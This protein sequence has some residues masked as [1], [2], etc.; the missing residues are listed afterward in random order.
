MLF[1]QPTTRSAP[2]WSYY[3]FPLGPSAG[4]S[5]E[6]ASAG[7]YSGL[8][9]LGV[10]QERG[11]SS[12][13]TRMGRLRL[14]HVFQRCRACT[15]YLKG[16]RATVTMLFPSIAGH[17]SSQGIVL[18]E[19]AIGA[20]SISTRSHIALAV[21]LA[22]ILHHHFP[23]QGMQMSGSQ[24]PTV[25]VASRW[26]EPQP[27]PA[28]TRIWTYTCDAPVEVPFVPAPEPALMYHQVGSNGRGIPAAG[29][30]VWTQPRIVQ[31]CAHI[32]HFPPRAHPPFVF[33]LLHFQA[34]G[35]VVAASDTAFDWA[36]IGALAAEAFN[37]PWFSQGAY[38]IVLHGRVL[39][40]GEAIG[41]PPHGTI[42]HLTRTSLQPR[43]GQ[44]IWDTPADPGC[45][46]PFDYDI[47]RGHR[48]H[49]PVYPLM[50]TGPATSTG[51]TQPARR[52]SDNTASLSLGHQ[53]QSANP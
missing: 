30:F 16:V 5:S 45:V 47:C 14:F 1:S 4:G 21:V 40:Y 13:S 43:A 37:E 27:D 15:I 24:H 26:N 23:A 8:S 41:V 31:G 19:V 39:S 46:I 20:L 2:P 22:S 44:S 18:V 11:M 52:E 50:P 29:D 35:H 12:R 49:L 42:L 10:N 33:W 3:P 34:R 51:S 28:I 48:G 17:M 25:L 9:P 6:T 36:Y 53:L 7:S 38:G 32:I